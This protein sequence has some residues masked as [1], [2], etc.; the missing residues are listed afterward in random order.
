MNSAIF[1]VLAL[2]AF[3]VNAADLPCSIHPKEGASPADLQA[4]AKVTKPMAE[5]VALGVVR[6]ASAVVESSELEAENG[7]LIYTFD[8]KVPRKKSVVEV[9]IDAGTG[10]VLSRKIEG[11][12][13]QAAEAAAD[14]AGGRER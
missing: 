4:L 9:A 3:G 2:S 11:P 10:Q 7:C 12:K 6:V 1:A 5:R 14:R 8:I 13:A